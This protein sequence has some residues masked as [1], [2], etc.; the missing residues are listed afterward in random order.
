MRISDYNET[1]IIHRN[2]QCRCYIFTS[3]LCVLIILFF[4]IFVK[5]IE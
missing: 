1:D 2:N 5:K 3:L 4:L